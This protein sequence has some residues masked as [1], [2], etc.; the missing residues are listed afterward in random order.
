ME[1]LEPEIWY[2]RSEAKL[3]VKTRTLVVCWLPCAIYNLH[4][5]LRC[6]VPNLRYQKNPYYWRCGADFSRDCSVARSPAKNRRGNV[7]GL[8]AASECVGNGRTYTTPKCR[9]PR[10]LTWP[11]CDPNTSGRVTVP[12]CQR[13]TAPVSE[14]NCQSY[15]TVEGKPAPLDERHGETLGH[16]AR[17]HLQRAAAVQKRNNPP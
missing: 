6:Q 16:S 11:R 10:E 5:C 9:V 8:R 15:C 7:Q 3:R 12:H 14:S 13:S 17:W 2:P 4:F 1:L